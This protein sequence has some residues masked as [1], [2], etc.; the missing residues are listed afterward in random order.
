M[1]LQNLTPRPLRRRLGA[2][3]AA[4]RYRPERRYMRGGRAA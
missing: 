4:L 3:I 2:W 1:A